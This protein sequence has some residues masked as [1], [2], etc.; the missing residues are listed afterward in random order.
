MPKLKSDL[1]SGSFVRVISFIIQLLEQ[2]ASTQWRL[3][4][5][6]VR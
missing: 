5:S 1:A 3:E 2:W 6:S 4:Y